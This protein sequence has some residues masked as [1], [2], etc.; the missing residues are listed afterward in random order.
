MSDAVLRRRA[1]SPATQATVEILTR[2]GFAVTWRVN[3][4]ND[5]RLRVN[6]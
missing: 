3:R 2:K 1:L 6:G 4:N 5:I